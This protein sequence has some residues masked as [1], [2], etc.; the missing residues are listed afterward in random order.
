MVYA[1]FSLTCKQCDVTYAATFPPPASIVIGPLLIV[2]GV[3]TKWAI[4]P[5]VVDNVVSD[6]I[7]VKKAN[8]LNWLN[9]SV[10]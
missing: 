1:L 6:S 10:M 3:A 2:L 7:Y 5:V 4:F 8:C 9:F